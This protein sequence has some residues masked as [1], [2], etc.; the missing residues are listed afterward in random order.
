MGTSVDNRIVKMQFDNKQFESGCKTTLNTL[1]KLKQSLNFQ[2]ASDS[3]KSLASSINNFSFGAMQKGID[4]MTNKFSVLGTMTDQFIRRLTDQLMSTGKMIASTFTIDPIK[5]GFEEYT[6][7]IDAVQTILANTQSKGTTLDDVNNALDELNQY[8]DKTIYNFTEMTRNIGTFTAAGVDLDTSVTAIQGIANLAAISGS[9]S[10]QAST[11]MYQLSQALASGTVKLQDWNSVVNAGMGGQ[12]FQDALKETARE[13]GISIDSMIKDAGSFRESLSKG[14]LTTDVLTAT[15]AKFTDESTEL[16]KTATDAATKVK[17]FSQLWDTMKEAVQ[18]GWTKTWEMIIGDFEEA[19]STL[20]DVNNFFDGLIQRYNDARNSQVKLWKEAGGRERLIKSFWNIIEGIKSAIVPVQKALSNFIPAYTAER[21]IRLTYNFEKFTEKLAMSEVTAKKVENALRGF[22]GV[23]HLGG[24]V[25]TSVFKAAAPYVAKLLPTALNLFSELGEKISTFTE[26]LRHNNTVMTFMKSA[27]EVLTNA[28]AALARIVQAVYVSFKN[29]VP[30]TTIK[31]VSK[32]SGKLMTLTKR[33]SKMLNAWDLVNVT[34][35]SNAFAEILALVIDLAD[36]LI[37]SLT[38]NGSAT[39]TFFHSVLELVGGLGEMVSIVVKAIR[40]SGVLQGTIRVICKIIST[41]ISL[42][43]K[44]VKGI[45]SVL[46]S[47]A[48]FIKSNEKLKLILAA[49]KKLLDDLVSVVLRFKDTIVETFKAIK[50]SEGVQNLLDQLGKLWDMLSSM[51]SER[52]AKAAENLDSFVQAGSASSPFVNFVN[53]ASNLANQLATIVGVLSSGGNPFE[54][55]IA[56]IKSGDLSGLATI[57]STYAWIASVSKRGIIKTA[58]MELSNLVDSFF[59]DGIYK[60]S[61]GL[62]SFFTNFGDVMSSIQWDKVLKTV[63]S[64]VT[65]ISVVRTLTSVKKSVDELTKIF[66]SFSAIGNNLN[67]LFKGWTN[68]AKTA[69]KTLRVKMF[70]SIAL[71]VAALAASLWIIAQIPADRLKASVETLSIVF[72]ELVAAIAI[73]SSPIFNDKKITSIGVAFAGIG[74][75]LLAM[76]GAIK[77]I[78]VLDMDTIKTGMERIVGILVAFAAASRL[79]GKVSKTSAMILAMAVAINLLVPAIYILGKIDQATATQGVAVVVAVMEGLALA[80]RIGNTAGLDGKGGK[81]GA[82]FLAMAIAIDL[83]VPAIIVLGKLDRETA[84]QGAA[85]V[86]GVVESLAVA[87]RIAGNNRKGIGEAIAIVL[88]IAAITGALYVLSSLDQNGIIAGA[89]CISAVVLSISAATRLMDTKNIVKQIVLFTVMLGE[90]V[91]GLLILNNLTNPE[92]LKSIADSMAEILL[93]IAVATRIMGGLK[94]SML[95]GIGVGM[96]AIAGFI[97][98]FGGVLVALATLDNV[99]S[100]ATGGKYTLEGLLNQGLPL[101]Q[102]IAT[103]IG[104]FFGNILGGVVSGWMGGVGSGLPKIGEGLSEFW[105]KAKPFFNGMKDLGGSDALSG[106]KTLTAAFASLFAAEFVNTLVNNPLTT[107]LMG[108]KNPMQEL[109]DDMEILVHG[110]DGEGG[111]KAFAEECSEINQSDLEKASLAATALSSIAEAATKIPN[112]GGWLGEIFGENNIGGFVDELPKVGMQ[113]VAYAK[114]VSVITDDMIDR[115]ET[116][117]DM[118]SNIC[119]T[120]KKIPNDGGLIADIMGENNIGTFVGKLPDVAVQLGAYAEGCMPISDEMIK[121]SKKVMGMLSNICKTAQNIPNEG[122]VLADWVGDNTIGK[123][124]EYLPDVGEQF[125][126]YTNNI[127]DI[128]K[129]DLDNSNKVMDSLSYIVGVASKIPN[130]GGIISWI[131][132][133]NKMDE[134]AKNLKTFAKSF[135]DYLD[136]LG[137]NLNDPR[138]NLTAK[139]D[140]IAESAKKLADMSMNLTKFGN[141]RIESFGNNVESFGKSMVAYLTSLKD[142]GNDV[143]PLNEKILLVAYGLDKLS[144]SIATTGDGR[145]ATFGG[146]AESFGKGLKKYYDYLNAIDST[147]VQ[148]VTTMSQMLVNKMLAL[149]VAISEVSVLD[150][151]SYEM[152][153]FGN[154]F[155]SFYNNVSGVDEDATTSATKSINKV[156][157]SFKT[158]KDLDTVAVNNFGSALKNISKQG[159]DNFMK[160]FTESDTKVT[161]VINE[162]M[163]NAKTIVENNQNGIYNKFFG[164]GSFASEGFENGLTSRLGFVR[165]A[166]MS[167]ANEALNAAQEALDSHS[168]SRE[169][170]KLGEYFSQGMAIGI[171]N[172]GDSVAE[173]GFTIADKAKNALRESLQDISSIANGYV[174]IDPTIR[175]TV[176][177]NNVYRGSDAAYGYMNATSIRMSRL[178]SSGINAMFEAESGYDD[179]DV[180]AAIN[181]LQTD[182]QTLS[183]NMESIQM[184]MDTGAVVGQLTKP[185]DKALGRMSVWRARRN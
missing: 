24:T 119:K 28:L 71:G 54:K 157:A 140:A 45:T 149:A 143:F 105:D 165:D 147:D 122:G 150:D 27:F 108:G 128:S 16:G 172:L 107:L 39:E 49:G 141:Q 117:M 76:I 15:L 175:P 22:F 142:I 126:D 72:A 55:L 104:D 125:A 135:I 36:T 114:N 5:T 58:V 81:G 167:V 31:M 89:G 96:V 154:R 46:T 41:T 37:D 43:A 182:I 75:G 69:Q 159:I 66:S 161:N 99:V 18:S 14:W 166:A 70:E 48:T 1:D 7:Q 30:N 3:L 56:G 79:A 52:V 100:N 26:R 57:Q 124:V 127:K 59:M 40:E 12:V 63:T 103:A 9:T 176:D 146:W 145:L 138:G 148:R 106:V 171:S 181:G 10:Q 29:I 64:V 44:V 153:L 110:E 21:L 144:D 83:I 51:A 2:G 35:A 133:D 123:F 95:E 4:A 155:K 169:T 42:L 168:P 101:L 183:E 34:K 132:G 86:V 173:S 170:M 93:S 91:G 102:T 92:G 74:I 61:D 32:L 6:T 87:A 33:L 162:F 65:G 90:M 13:F 120:A 129:A 78:T 160:S 121:K 156:I 17:T 118:L 185:M 174:M 23:F 131:A 136:Y 178:A 85:V 112:D 38:L 134:F 139:S 47:I 164:L 113:L 20:T 8:A 111:I 25:I 88:E 82:S 158:M 179:S 177:M 67:A 116:V 97:A 184:V 109:M 60:V 98:E 151:S 19:K 152:Q 130:E 68:V 163:R 115:S 84:I 73:L 137:D 62:T 53:L 94:V 80:A 77:L 180:I 50:D 11:A